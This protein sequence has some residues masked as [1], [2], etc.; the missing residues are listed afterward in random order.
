M[1]KNRFTN[2]N[3]KIFSIA[4]IGSLGF[5]VYLSFNWLS[6]TKNE[7][8]ITHIHQIDF[9]I[10]EKIGSNYLTVFNVRN[11]L[12]AAV[13][14][15]EEDYLKKSDINVT[16]IKDS[17]NE[18]SRLNPTLNKDIKNLTTLFDNYYQPARAVAEALINDTIDFEELPEQVQ[19][20]NKNYETFS[21]QL[22]IFSE[23][24]THNFSEALNNT[25]VESNKSFTG[26]LWLGACVLILIWAAAWNVS[27][28]IKGSVVAVVHSLIDM[29]SGK[30]DLTLRLKKQSNDEIGE[31]VTQF[32]HFISHQQ[33]LIGSITELAEGV[34]EASLS[35]KETAQKTQSELF[36]QQKEILMVTSAITEMSSSA[37]E[38]TKNAQEVVTVTEEADC[39]SQAG[40]LV[41]QDNIEAINELYQEIKSAREVI[42]SLA[43]ESEHINSVSDVIQSIAEQT[44][45]LALNAAIEA[46]RA[47]EHG[48]GFAVVADEVRTLASRTQQSTIE[49][50][51]R[52][53][54][55]NERS[56]LAVA[57]M[58]KGM[59]KAL[60]SVNKSN[61]AGNTLNSIATF[62]VKIKELNTLVEHSTHEQSNVASEVS[63][64]ITSIN[65]V[66]E[67]TA[68]Q[69]ESVTNTS[70]LLSNQAQELKNMMKKFKI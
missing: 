65:S 3:V 62:V 5:F 22:N 16:K 21:T 26:G 4:L 41:V 36:N 27:R 38:V 13:S 59:E 39:E 37:Q 69:S 9:P 63:Q 19:Q 53:Q 58:E 70:L 12:T 33:T 25:L 45:L 18:I 43:K 49:I 15:G 48:R 7:Q 11:Q 68:N 54:S 24:N 2:L 51:E 1:N 8:H 50:K 64:S 20:I 67:E 56:A 44:N 60:N 35:V 14:E 29:A 30:G 61:D 55:L 31:L 47:G 6:S 42:V 34:S 52:I 46:A 32:N 23:N 28:M 40:L 10:I 57:A 66:S 17:L